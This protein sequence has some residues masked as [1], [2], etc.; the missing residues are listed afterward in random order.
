MPQTK[1]YFKKHQ[2]EYRQKWKTLYV[3]EGVHKAIKLYAPSENKTVQQATAD[4]IKYGFA[5]LGFVV[6]KN[7]PS[8]ELEYVRMRLEGLRHDMKKAE[9]ARLR[10]GLAMYDA[11][12]G[13]SAEPTEENDTA[14]EAI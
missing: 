9:I 11:G 14:G 12:A 8:P 10:K 1:R 4:V 2:R 5:L 6:L 3:S 13:D 7:P